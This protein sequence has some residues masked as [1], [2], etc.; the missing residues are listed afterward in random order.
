MQRGYKPLNKQMENKGKF[1]ADCQSCYYWKLFN[2]VEQCTNNGVTQFDMAEK[3]N[4]QVYCTF[5]IPTY[6]ERK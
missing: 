3:E 6:K 5:W 4:G 1:V 2:G